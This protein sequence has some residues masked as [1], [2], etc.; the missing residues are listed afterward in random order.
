MSV[1]TWGL[2]GYGNIGLEVARQVVIAHE[3]LGLKKLPDFVLRSDGLKQADARTPH[4]A[5]T[6][7]KLTEFPEVIFVALP[8]SDDGHPAYELIA[9]SLDRGALVIT[10]EKGASANNFASLQDLSDNFKR[11]GIQATV[12][13]GTRLM[14]AIAVVFA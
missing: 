11:L 6:I 1:K 7:E 9:H 8:S 3:R 4:H 5:K 10:S 13:G 14:E 2:L 12:G